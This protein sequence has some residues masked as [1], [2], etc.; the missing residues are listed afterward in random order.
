[1]KALP[2][3]VYVYREEDRDGSDYLVASTSS[4]D[5]THGLVGVYDLR[6]TLSVRHVAE[7][8]RPKSRR[9]FR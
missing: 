9:W 1:M 7:Y 6:E 2:K 3:I 8:R 5:Q 4:D